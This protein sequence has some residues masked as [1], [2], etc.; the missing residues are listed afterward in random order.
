[1]PRQKRDQDQAL[2]LRGHPY[3]TGLEPLDITPE[4]V[5]ATAELDYRLAR[6]KLIAMQ[7]KVI[8]EGDADPLSRKGR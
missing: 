1:M 6:D 5:L 7:L 3:K 2:P 4:Q 8:E